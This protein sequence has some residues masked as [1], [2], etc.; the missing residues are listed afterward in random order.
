KISEMQAAIQAEVAQYSIALVD[1]QLK[2]LGASLSTAGSLQEAGKALQAGKL[3]RAA[4][5]L[6]R[7]S[8]PPEDHKLARGVEEQVQRAA[9]NMQ[10][11]KLERLAAAT[12]KMASGVRGDKGQYRKGAGELAKEVRNHERRRR[13]NQ[14]LAFEQERL[15][16][17]K[18]RCQQNT[19][20]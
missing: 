7:Q 3:D 5:E 12:S 19:L 11:G 6:D 1:A 9:R 20:A 2:E 8:E 4:E 10:A 18:N 14:L 16:E 13:I 17:C 15:T